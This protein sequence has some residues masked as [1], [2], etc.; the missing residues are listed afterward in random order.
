MVKVVKFFIFM[1][2]SYLVL[3]PSAFAFELCEMSEE[4]K[5]W[6]ELSDE[7]RANSIQPPF[8]KSTIRD[9]YSAKVILDSNKYGELDIN[10]RK[11]LELKASVSQSRYNAVDDGIITSVKNQGNTNT[12]WAFT[13]NSLIE[14]VAL[15]SGLGTY[16][17]SE[18]H[19]EYAVTRNGFTENYIKTN[20]YNRNIDAGGNSSMSSSY[21][22]RHE[23]PVLESTMPFVN[24]ISKISINSLPNTGAVLDIDNYEYEYFSENSACTQSQIANIKQRI[25]THGSAGASMYFNESYLTGGKFYY[26]RGNTADINKSEKS[27]HAVTI[28]GWDDS[29]STSNFT[30]SPSRSGAWIV[31]N[32]WG[33]SFGEAGYIYISYADVKICGNSYNY[34]GVS[35]NKYNYTYSS[36]DL[37]SSHNLKM[38]SLHYSSTK[39]NKQYSGPEVLDKV[40]IEVV[41]GNGYAVYLS[42]SNTISSQNDWQLLGSGTALYDGIISVRFTPVTITGDYT[43]IVKRTGSDYYI[44]LMCK[45]TSSLDKY[46]YANISTGKNYYSSN[47][48]SWTDYST[49]NVKGTD[50]Y[51]NQVTMITGCNPIIYAYTKAASVTG[52]D[53]NISSITGNNSTVYAGTG[54]YFNA[55]ITSSGIQSF[56]TFKIKVLNSSGSDVTSKFTITNYLNNGYAKI[57]PGDIAA[58]TY[59]LRMEYGTIA[60]TKTFVVSKLY[61]SGVYYLNNGYLII[62]AKTSGSMTKAIFD[63]NI[64]FGNLSY[65]ILNGNGADVT[66]TTSIIGT[67]YR[68]IVGGRTL[69]VALIGDITGDGKIMSNDS[70]QISRYL[71]DLRTLTG[72]YQLAAD[73]SG[74]GLIRS[75]DSLLISRFLVGLRGS[76]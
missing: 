52:S 48:Y 19:I 70:L 14:T 56:N 20:G 15:K 65:K 39:F 6:I 8:C 3:I 30:S 45:T 36:A 12:C 21:Y 7:E 25:V 68:I 55:Y 62:N 43:I 18:R 49:L 23:G 27:N 69:Y 1:F 33:T 37:M 10:E 40:S 59:T 31:K 5:S 38:G 63:K 54:D 16:D 11:D 44:P 41:K 76:L 9:Q 35:L 53:F 42:K 57:V 51:G 67:N 47:G 32:S 17:F 13:S 2:L 64:S 22:F 34:S 58:G 74:D 24:S 61:T 29:I 72:A 4:Y 50:Q 60:R 46:Y 75:N 73:V 26:Y 28:V 71:V 66:S